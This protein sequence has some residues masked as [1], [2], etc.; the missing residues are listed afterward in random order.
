MYDLL[1]DPYE[2]NS[3]ADSPRYAKQRRA[4][5]KRLAALRDCAGHSCRKSPRLHLQAAGQAGRSCVRNPVNIGVAGPE[6]KQLV[7]VVFT[8]PGGK[9]TKDTQAPF[10]VAA[11]AGDFRPPAPAKAR[12]DLLD[13]RQV[14]LSRQFK[15]CG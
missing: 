13:G 10:R 7:R 2:L 15:G 12:A 6:A 9:Q 11:K 8:L 3:L 1:A 4:L 14:L 5:A